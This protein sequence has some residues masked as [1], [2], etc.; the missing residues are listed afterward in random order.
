MKD[1]Q[2]VLETGVSLTPTQSA[3]SE[4][5]PWKAPALTTWKIED[6]TLEPDGSAR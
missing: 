5:Q 1:R 6:E 4:P 3:Q 2:E